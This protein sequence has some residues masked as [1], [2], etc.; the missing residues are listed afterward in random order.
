MLRCRDKTLFDNAPSH[1][2]LLDDGAF[3]TIR[4]FIQ[5]RQRFVRCVGTFAP[6]R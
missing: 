6:Q 5:V 4:A 3:A 2:D 1:A